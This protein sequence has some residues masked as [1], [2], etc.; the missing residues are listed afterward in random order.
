MFF[1]I[2][3]RWKEEDGSIL[4]TV[5]M[6]LTVLSLLGTALATASFANVNLSSVDRAY[7]STF[8][9][10]E[11]GAN[12]TY[13]SI[14][15][16]VKDVYN[17]TSNQAEFY[18]TFNNKLDELDN[19]V[20]TNFSSVFEDNPSANISIQELNTTN[21]R[22]YQ[23]VSEGVIGERARTVTRPF[24][25]NWTSGNV[26]NIPDRAVAIVKNDINLSGSSALKGNVYIKS[27]DPNTINMRGNPSITDGFAYVPEVAVDQALNHSGGTPPGV[28]PNIDILPWTA[29][30]QIVDS[31]PVFP[32]YPLADDE[33]VGSFD[34][35][36]NGDLNI[37]NYQ[38]DGYTLN[39]SEDISLKNISIN[40]NY[41]LQINTNNQ[42]VDIVVNNLN[43]T[44]G[45]VKII[46]R[47][48]VNFYI[49]NKL[50]VGSGSEVNT[51]GS[52]NQ[53]NVYLAGNK[54]VNLAGSTNINGSLFAEAADVTLSGGGGFKGFIVTG[55]NNVTFNG[56]SFSD[57]LLLAPNANVNVKGGAKI[58]GTLIGNSLTG[59]GGTGV[60][61]KDMSSEFP[62]DSGGSTS[63]DDL[64]TKE[65]SVEIN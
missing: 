53:V 25:I 32:S 60:T 14:E 58:T 39:L 63:D 51:G 6:T 31:F 50:A 37:T 22:N 2:K 47:G 40:S 45:K 34:V 20:L 1:S 13:A 27:S 61:Y 28:K 36:K 16:I 19:K 21:P 62:F 33:R 48:T 29:Y 24:Q 43:V 11:G 49:K 12:Q 5:L 42:N 64:I 54:S 9:I 4:A 57:L 8:Y 38:A 55:G 7:Q 18:T 10:A 44:N 59:S 52:I 30:H 41:D 3:D 65:P 23:I 56:G 17:T 35:I 15:T 26:L 46:G